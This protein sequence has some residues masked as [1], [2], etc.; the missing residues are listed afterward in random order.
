MRKESTKNTEVND[1]IA[2]LVHEM[3]ESCDDSMESHE[4]KHFVDEN[5]A[6]DIKAL[7][8]NDGI[9]VEEVLTIGS[10]LALSK[11][12]HELHVAEGENIAR[13]LKRVLRGD[14]EVEVIMPDDMPKEIQDIVKDIVNVIKKN[15]KGRK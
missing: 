15:R 1:K 4:L 5:N 14:A 7:N 10:Y 3:W 6:P 2:K 9:G 13:Q 8:E 11:L 12:H